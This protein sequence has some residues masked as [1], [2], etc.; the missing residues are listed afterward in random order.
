M[1]HIDVA[2]LRE[3]FDYHPWNGWL[4]H[5]V[6]RGKARKGERAGCVMQPSGYRVVRIGH[7]VHY[8]HRVIWALVTGDQP[9]KKI[10]HRNGA[11]ADNRFGNF[12]AA[13]GSQNNANQSKA[14]KHN[15]IGVLGVRE[16]DGSFQARI[17]WQGVEYTSPRRK[18]IEEAIFD[19]SSLETQYHGDFAAHRGASA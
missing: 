14:Q 17:M 12:R 4:T 1:R 7:V 18:T 8:E 11:K 9:P 16:V 19:R 5:K 3:L 10:D 13:T 6:N 15:L 2:Q